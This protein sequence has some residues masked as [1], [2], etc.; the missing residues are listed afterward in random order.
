MGQKQQQRSESL[1]L[2]LVQITDFGWKRERKWH[3]CIVSS[4]NIN[5][6]DPD[7]QGMLLIV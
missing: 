6:R 7:L 5:L 3:I 4:N 2:D 1:P